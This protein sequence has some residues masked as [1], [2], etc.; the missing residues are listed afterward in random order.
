MIVYLWTPFNTGVINR[1][2][3]NNEVPVNIFETNLYYIWLKKKMSQEFQ[4]Q[5]TKDKHNVKQ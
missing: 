2:H 4:Y 3:H 1:R 5:L